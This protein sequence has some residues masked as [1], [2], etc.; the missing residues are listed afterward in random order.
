MLDTWPRVALFLVVV[1]GAALFAARLFRGFAAGFHALGV[2]SAALALPIV[3]LLIAHPRS[4]K[5]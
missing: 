2:F 5:G 3:V 1:A 4:R